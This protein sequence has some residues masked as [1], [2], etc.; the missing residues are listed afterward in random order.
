MRRAVAVTMLPL[1]LVLTYALPLRADVSA[2]V[3]LSVPE[4]GTKGQPLTQFL[5]APPFFRPNSQYCR[6]TSIKSR[7]Y[8]EKSP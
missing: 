6:S 4:I 3:N 5:P 7:S 8:G 1:I 2:S